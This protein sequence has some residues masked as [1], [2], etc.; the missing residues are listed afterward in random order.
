MAGVTIDVYLS[1]QDEEATA[2]AIYPNCSH[3]PRVG[4]HFGTHGVV[5]MVMWMP[6][7]AQDGAGGPWVPTG[8][9]YVELVCEDAEAA[10][11]REDAAI[12]ALRLARSGIAS[13]TFRPVKP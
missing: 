4:D 1:T 12:E 11:A 5:V 3:V 8:Q 9:F 2:V 10:Q 6:H 13:T 7:V